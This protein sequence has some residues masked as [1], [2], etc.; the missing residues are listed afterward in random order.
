M[1]QE[2]RKPSA[3]AAMLLAAARSACAPAVTGPGGLPITVRG[4][5]YGVAVKVPLTA[6]TDQMRENVY[7]IFPQC[8]AAVLAAFVRERGPGEGLKTCQAAQSSGTG[9]NIL[10]AIGVGVGV[11]LVVFLT[12]IW[13]IVSAL[14]TG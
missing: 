5:A 14:G 8:G 2:F 7:V 1:K 13:A 12:F 4:Q 11:G 3:V 9:T 6:F 10:K